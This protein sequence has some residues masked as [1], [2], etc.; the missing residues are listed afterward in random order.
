MTKRRFPKSTAQAN[1]LVSSCTI[2]LTVRLNRM[3]HRICGIKLNRQVSYRN[4][5]IF[6]VAVPNTFEARKN[7]LYPHDL[8]PRIVAVLSI[9]SL[10][11]MDLHFKGKDVPI[12]CQLHQLHVTCLMLDLFKAVLAFCQLNSISGNTSSF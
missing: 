12:C 1:N 4:L 7:L 8:L 10:T 2:Y 3:F 5:S 9:V 6:V 11:Y